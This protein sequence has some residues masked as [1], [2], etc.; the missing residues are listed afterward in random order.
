MRTTTN[1]LVVDDEEIVRLSYLRTLA[2]NQ[3]KVQAAENGTDA[4]ELMGQQRFDVVLL[5]QMM[6]GMDGMMVLKRIKAQWPET[7]VI[8]ITGFPAMESAKEAVALGAF[9]YL[10]K[11]VGPDEVL[12]AAQC[13]M[14]HK[15]WGLRRDEIKGAIQ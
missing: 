13:A 8:M 15:R 2:G 14:T 5:D 9:D 12:S 7:E 3:C 11:P 6:P 1:V 10:S 4:L